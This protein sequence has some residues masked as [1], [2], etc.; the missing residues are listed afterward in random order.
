MNGLHS[1]Y[2]KKR[3]EL[4]ETLSDLEKL[5][6]DLA[7]EKGASSWLTALP[8]KSFGFLLN[9]QEFSDAI[10]IRYNLNLK[11]T[12]TSCACGETNSNTINHSLI[13][14]K[15]GYVS[16]R[17]NSLCKVTAGLLTPIC[18]DVRLEPCLLPTAG[19]V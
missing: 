12:A 4:Y 18:K 17:H 10:C 2:K 8:L 13:C 5:Q 14:K 16:L 7:A 6:L 11:N 9:K 19:A 1:I 15:G 3:H